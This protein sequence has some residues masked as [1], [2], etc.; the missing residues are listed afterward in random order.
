MQAESAFDK[1]VERNESDSSRWG[2]KGDTLALTIGDSDFRLPGP[3]DK[4]IRAR[5]DGIQGYDEVSDRLKSAIRNRLARLYDWQIEPEWL[6]FMPG[7]VQGLNICC[8]ACLAEGDAA[9]SE[10]P[11][12]YPFLDAPGNAG[13]KLLELPARED[14]TF[15]HDGFQEMCSRQESRLFMLCHPQNPLGRVLTPED[16]HGI[17]ETCIQE[18]LLICSDEIHAEILYGD[19]RHLPMAKAHPEIAARTITLTSP[20]KAFA[21]SG[22]G[23]AFAIIPDRELRNRF[24]HW[25]AGLVPGVSVLTLAAMQAAYTECDE[26]LQAELRYLEASRDFLVSRL[27]GLSDIR[28]TTPE[29]T[30]FLWLDFRGTGL[31]DPGQRLLDCGIELSDGARF[32]GPG[33]LRLNYASPRSV[34]EE[35]VCRIE[36][37]L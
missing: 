3:I 28:F 29:A 35:A 37:A 23:G 33:F 11:V 22:L 20:S 27:Q 6:L 9:I 2:G 10:V 4:A 24:R 7:V 5:L 32:G 8:R 16:L 1:I 36:K 18:D 25:S 31:N 21:M 17:A 26:W 30:Y 13:R 14:G 19:A 12:Y 15:D 34:L